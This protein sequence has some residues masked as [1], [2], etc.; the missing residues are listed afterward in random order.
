MKKLVVCGDSWMTPD[1][2]KVNTH[3][4]ELLA[5]QYGFDDVT[6]Y[7]RGGMSNGGIALQIEQAIKDKPDL[8]L[9]GTTVIDR[10]ELS[11]DTE[12]DINDNTGGAVHRYVEQCSIASDMYGTNPTLISDNLM[13][14]LYEPIKLKY[15]LA[16]NPKEKYNAIRQWFMHMYSPKMKRK[17][18]LWCMS[19][20][21][22]KLHLSGIPAVLVIDL[23]NMPTEEVPWYTCITED[24]YR[25]NYS[26]HQDSA[27]YHT[28]PEQQVDILN[29]IVNHMGL[30]G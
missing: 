22:H 17:L 21:L 23:L 7:A 1:P 9:I 2:S 18:D 5:A 4:S 24:T 3:F 19:A 6:C 20:V 29:T 16:A 26:P 15:P 25:K 28:L 27:S 11:M 10:I 12:A 13:S 14:L 30:R 8:V